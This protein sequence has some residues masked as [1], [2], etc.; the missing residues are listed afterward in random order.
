MAKANMQKTK[1]PMTEL[2]PAYRATC[3]EEVAGGYTLEEAVN[4]AQRCI[5]CKNHPCVDGCPVGVPIPSFLKELGEG[6]VG[7]AYAIV[8]DANALP[9]ICGRVCPQESQCEGK[10]TRG[11][12]G[13]P[14]GIGRLERFVADWALANPEEAAA[15]QQA[16]AEQTGADVAADDFDYTGKKVA[17]VGSGPAGLTCAGELAKRGVRGDACSRR[18]TKWAACSSTASRSSAC[19]RPW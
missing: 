15:A 12:N 17:I 7:A 5:H 8:K 1:T 13:E 3:F 6:N 2:D 9:A 11:R 16:Y 19:R 10:C 4:E 18:C 14:V